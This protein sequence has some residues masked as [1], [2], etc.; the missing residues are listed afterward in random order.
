M[1][2]SLKK[3]QAPDIQEKNPVILTIDDEPDVRNSIQAYL[4]DF[5]YVVYGA[6]N[7][8]EGL[9][10]FQEK[11]IDLIL[12]DLRMP[13]MDGLEVLAKVREINENMPIIV[14]SGTGEISD[15]VEALRRGAW[16]YLLKPI[17]DLSILIH[18]IEKGLERA[19]LRRENRSYQKRLENKFDETTDE[20]IRVN[21]R[22]K[23]VVESTK[24]LLG[25][26][27]LQES[28]Q[29][30]LEEF[31]KHMNAK[32]GSI[33]QVVT[34]GLDLLYSLDPGH[35][36]EFL[37]FPLKKNSPFDKALQSSEPFY[38]VDIEKND[39]I[40]TSGWKHYSDNSTLI[41][42]IIERSGKTIAIIALHSKGEPFIMQD[43]EIG[44]ILA[45]YASEVMQTA[46]AEAA[47]QRNEEYLRQAQ[48]M[49]AIGTLASGIAHDFNNI[50]SAIVGYTDLSMFSGD[51]SPAIEKNLQQIKKASNRARDLVQQI[52]SFSRSDSF[53]E[54]AVDIG[55][56]IEEVLKLL[57]AIIPSSIAIEHDV[58]IGLGKTITDPTRVHQLL[59][60]LCTNAAQAMKAGDGL[61]RITFERLARAELPDDVTEMGSDFC[62]RL[63][64]EDNGCGIEG[65]E[66]SKIF[67][68][69]YTTK[70]KG[71]GTGLGLA[72]VHGIVTKSGGA[73][74]LSSEVGIGSTFQIY[75]PAID[76][77]V[78]KVEPQPEPLMPRGDER[79]LFVDDETTLADVV[80]EM[81]TTLGYRVDIMTSSVDTLKLLRNAPDDYHLLITDQTMPVLSGVELSREALQIKPDL[82]IIL[83]TGF[84]TAIDHESVQEIGIKEFLMKP[85]SMNR[86]AAVIR[87][88]LDDSQGA[89]L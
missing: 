34:D 27:E 61:I 13:E 64:V 86:L 67:D 47:L 77:V 40:E 18:A 24:K 74:R 78:T 66:V 22:L 39:S 41:L 71:E 46:Q 80:G 37:P 49:D 53:E 7:G 26:G 44:T 19:R 72:V 10:V 81:L 16:D 11:P 52:L 75:F 21:Q 84:S 38:V 14:I 2:E 88:V 60:N 73:I 5:D 83:F 32:G 54:S 89:R 3:S 9:S 55:P 65:S 45:S 56:I 51:L 69:Y 57:R 68:P 42:P 63:T 62:L 17:N 43:K 35:A 76:T 15:V 85:L 8:R 70:Q 30:I 23:D 58:P 20:L 4:E 1:Q 29:V 87:D 28:G 50:L 12:V 31:G 79:I 25:C 6:A 33:Y 82:P 36:N 59:M 48:K